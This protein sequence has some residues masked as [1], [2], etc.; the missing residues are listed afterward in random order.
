MKIFNIPT[1]KINNGISNPPPIIFKKTDNKILT[2]IAVARVINKDFGPDRLINILNNSECDYRLLIVGNDSKYLINIKKKVE[3]M[4]LNN[5]IIFLGALRDEELSKLYAEADVGIS[6]LA[7]DRK[8]LKKAS[9]LKS[10]EYLANGLPVIY[11]YKDESIE[12]FAFTFN[13]DFEIN[14]FKDIISFINTTKNDYSKLEIS[15][16]AFKFLS[17]EIELKKVLDKL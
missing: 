17:W 13:I 16:L 14:S 11:S 1:I 2:M 12:D 10:R 9:T 3:K 4:K 5:K 8:G 7:I 15:N 6:S